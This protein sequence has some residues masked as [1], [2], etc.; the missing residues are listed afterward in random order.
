MTPTDLLDRLGAEGVGVSLNLKLEADEKPS[1]ETLDLIRENR[2]ALLE[3]LAVEVYGLRNGTHESH[4]QDGANYQRASNFQRVGS[5]HLYGDLLHSLMVWIAQHQELRLERPG[6]TV[7]N[8]RPEHI[9]DAVKLYPW[10]VVYDSERRVLV[11]WGDVPRVTLLGLRDL[12]TDELL[13]PK[14]V[15]A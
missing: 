6:A 13:I 8:A 12:E 9:R 3:H 1:D 15:A 7:R 2:D 10:G 4:L 5:L 11:T 14:A